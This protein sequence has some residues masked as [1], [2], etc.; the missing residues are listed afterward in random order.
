M[1]ARAAAST[2]AE[3]ASLPEAAAGLLAVMCCRCVRALWAAGYDVLQVC[4]RCGQGRT[5]AAVVDR[6]RLPAVNPR[7][8]EIEMSLACAWRPPG[9]EGTPVCSGQAVPSLP[10]LVQ[11]GSTAGRRSTTT[12][13]Y[14]A[15]QDLVATAFPTSH[16]CCRQPPLPS[17]SSLLLPIALQPHPPT[18]P[19]RQPASRQLDPASQAAVASQAG[20]DAHVP[21]QHQGRL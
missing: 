15:S 10:S 7:A 19:A 21:A 6:P 20:S 11:T 14:P 8:D 5:A 4:A 13:H 12:P 9:I 17:L 1:L 3:P 18:H 16:H 2:A